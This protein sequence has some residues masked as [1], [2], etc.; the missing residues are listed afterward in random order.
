[1]GYL[2]YNNVCNCFV[3]PYKSGFPLF[4]GPTDVA[5][6]YSCSYLLSNI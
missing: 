2:E 6:C 1:M 3:Q 4:P 5:A